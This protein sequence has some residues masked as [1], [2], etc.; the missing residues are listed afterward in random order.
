M[1]TTFDRYLLLRY[2]SAFGILFISTFGLFVVID[3]FTNLDAFHEN[4]RGAADVF[5]RMA[6]YY[7][8]QS[9]MF[10]DLAGPLVAVIA[11][12]VV[13]GLL[14]KHNEIHPILAAGI[15]T[16]RLLWPALGGTVLVNLILI[17]NQELLI[18]RI[19]HKI[20]AA[21]SPEDSKTEKVEP[22]YD[23]VSYILIDGR[24][25]NLDT[26]T[27][28]QA[29]FVLPAHE[30]AAELTTLR[31]AEATFHEETGERPAGWKLHDVSPRYNELE[32][33]EDGKTLVR[34]AEKPADLFVVTDVSFDQLYDRSRSYWLVST[35]ELI[36]RVRNPAFGIVSARGQTLHLHAR[37]IRPVINVICVLIAVP[38][39][40]RKESRSLIGN[41]ATCTGVLSLILGLA[42]LCLYMGQVNLMPLDLAAWVPL[43]VAAPLGTWLIGLMQ[44]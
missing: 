9:S 19:A 14:Q 16:S 11:V 27:I 10:F 29:K 13:F 28:R 42:H 5:R 33:T 4:A 26:R 35:P 1:L 38:L 7:A 15:P 40:L 43:L 18:P 12:M 37:L 3:G 25:L 2:L 31:A 24:E 6:G 36:R 44:T 32:L 8:F 20:Q 34:P 22:V 23:H 30:V 21:R 39:V 17:G 41:L